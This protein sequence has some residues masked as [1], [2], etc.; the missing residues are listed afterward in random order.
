MTKKQT[1]Y[2]LC[3][4]IKGALLNWNDA[5]MKGIFEDDGRVLSNTEAKSMLMDLLADG[6][7]VIPAGECDSFDKIAG[8]MR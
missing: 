8:G 1:N 6:H 5:E 7:K 3:M 4:S 2:H